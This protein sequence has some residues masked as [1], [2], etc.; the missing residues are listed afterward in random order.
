ME[1][2][3]KLR[4]SRLLRSSFH[5]CKSGNPMDSVQEPVFLANH[6]SDLLPLLPCSEKAGAAGLPLGVAIGWGCRPRRLPGST[7]TTATTSA[8][9][10]L[11]MSED[12]ESLVEFLHLVETRKAML[13]ARAKSSEGCEGEDQ[14]SDDGRSSRRVSPSAVSV[15]AEHANYCGTGEP[16]DARRVDKNDGRKVLSGSQERKMEKT[17]T[18]KKKAAKKKK[19]RK[20]SCRVRRKARNGDRNLQSTSSSDSGWFSSQED[21]QQRIDG[22][23]TEALFSSKSGSSESSELRPVDGSSCV[24][25]TSNRHQRRPRRKR[26]KKQSRAPQLNPTASSSSS[27]SCSSSASCCCC[28]Y[29]AGADYT[30]NQKVNDSVAVVKRSNDPYSDFRESMVEMIIEKQIFDHGD[31][32]QLLHCFLSLNSQYHH[33]VI[34]DVFWEIWHALFSA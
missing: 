29:G 15:T 21:K 10:Q 27:S 24:G 22:R 32:K 17:K 6:G 4:L 33:P 8:S 25:S 11:D 13:E 30:M 18:K 23:E 19:Q 28:S 3:L 5:S 1:T 14:S 20:E 16:N 26:E 9:D 34:I 12:D 31:L 2:R 7:A